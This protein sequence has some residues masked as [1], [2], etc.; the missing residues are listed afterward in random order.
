MSMFWCKRDR[1]L[2]EDNI[3]FIR[4][5]TLSLRKLGR[6]F[7]VGHKTIHY[8]KNDLNRTSE[9]IRTS[10]TSRQSRARKKSEINYD[11]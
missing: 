4:E 5:S 9:I 3:K 11:T 8:W 1:K 7:N 2:T 6:I 10:E